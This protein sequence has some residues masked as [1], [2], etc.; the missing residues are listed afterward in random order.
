MP[1]S[2]LIIVDIQNAFSS[3]VSSAMPYIQRLRKHFLSTSLPRIFTQHGQS[4]R[5]LTP[6]YKSQTV[7]RW[8]ADGSIA[9]G[10]SGFGFLPET[11]ELIPAG[12]Q[13]LQGK[14][15]YD[16]FV[17][18]TWPRYLTRRESRGS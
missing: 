15:T 10:S 8:G 5:E 9:R 16:A 7:R 18:T 2:A 14:N 4:K 3:M 17:N 13:V 1:K 11:E 12:G 6:P